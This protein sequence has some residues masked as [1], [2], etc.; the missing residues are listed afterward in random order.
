MKAH[1]KSWKDTGKHGKWSVR[2]RSG[3]LLHGKLTGKI[4]GTCYELHY[5]YGSGQKES[6]Y[7]N[8]LA[9]K[10][11]LNEIPFKREVS[12]T[13]KSEETAKRLGSHRL[14]FVIE[15]KVILEIKAVKFTPEKLKQQLFSYLKNSPYKVGLMVNFGSSKLYVKRI[16]LT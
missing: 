13:I 15:E 2:N 8:A 16:I 7:Q 4:I 14:D 1:W 5:K 3:K 6:V 9:E 11:S 12:I 10:L